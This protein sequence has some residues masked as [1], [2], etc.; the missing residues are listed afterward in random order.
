[1]KHF[2]KISF[3]CGLTIESDMIAGFLASFGFSF[4]EHKLIEQIKKTGCP[5]HSHNCKTKK[6]SPKIKK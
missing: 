5:I 6:N 2:L 3:P 1:M 4:N